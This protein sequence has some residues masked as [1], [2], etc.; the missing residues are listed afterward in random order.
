MP[1]KHLVGPGIQRPGHGKGGNS[2]R[3]LDVAVTL[4]QSSLRA[5]RP[6]APLPHTEELW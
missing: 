5:G 6:P 4:G 1:Q 3:T 2:G